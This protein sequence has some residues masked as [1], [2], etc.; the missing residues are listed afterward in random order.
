MASRALIRNTSEAEAARDGLRGSQAQRYWQNAYT[1]F[2]HHNGA[3]FRF[4]FQASEPWSGGH[5]WPPPRR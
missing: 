1:P 3:S 4:R 5:P 2:F